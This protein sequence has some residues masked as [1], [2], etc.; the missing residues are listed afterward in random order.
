MD[1]DLELKIS[2]TIKYIFDGVDLRRLSGYQKRQM[3]FSHL[4]DNLEYDFD[5]LDRIHDNEVNKTR[6]TRNPR[7]ELDSIVFNN[8]GIC[9]AISQYYKLLLEQVGIKSYCI[10]CDDGTAVNHQFTMV[11]DEGHNAYSFDDITS[12]IVGKGNKR[13]FFDYDCDYARSKGQGHKK[14]ME[15]EKFVVLPEEYIDYLVGR[16]QSFSETLTTLPTNVISIKSLMKSK[17]M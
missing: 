13:E 5:L 6:I 14:I 4:C 7:Q 12:V 17:E 3:I 11:Y 15:D 2:E 9:S 16:R 8:K 10:I 1:K